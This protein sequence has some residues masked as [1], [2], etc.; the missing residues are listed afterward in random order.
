MK[1]VILGKDGGTSK[2]LVRLHSQA[3]KREV[4]EL[5]NKRR[6][7]RAVEAAINKGKRIKEQKPVSRADLVLTKSR[8]SWDLVR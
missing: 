1:I 7:A 6:H 2:I 8:A 3:L 5:I 4:M